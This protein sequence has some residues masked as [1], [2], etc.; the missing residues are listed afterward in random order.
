MAEQDELRSMRWELD[1]LLKRAED[2]A[3][4]LDALEA[5][6]QLA[7]PEPVEERTALSRAQSIEIPSTPAK[8]PP[9]PPQEARVETAG[10][11]VL[12]M[13]AGQSAVRPSAKPRSRWVPVHTRVPLRECS[14][15]LLRVLGPQE[16][17]DW[18]M[19]LWTHW[20]PRIGMLVLAIGVMLLLT[21]AF[22]T[23]GLRW[24]PHLRLAFGYFV[25]AVLLILGK[26][27]EQ[28]ARSYAR[29]LIAGGLG[30][31]Y[32]ATF[33][34]HYLPYTRVV[35]RPEVTLLLLAA[36]V[37]VWA[38]VAQIRRSSLV[39]FGVTALGHLTIALSTLTL[40]EPSRFG[41]VGLVALSA[42]SA[43]FL[44][45]NGWYY[46]GAAG[47]VGSYAN[48]ALW[49][50]Y[51]APSGRPIDFVAAM[52]VLVVFVLLF[53]LAEL[54]APPRL[55]R[56][57][58]S[59][60]IRSLYVAFN[61][62][63][64]FFLAL[65]IMQAFPFSRDKTYLFYFAFA[66]GLAGMS[67]AYLKARNGDPLHNVYLTKGSAVSAL[68]LAA[69]FDGPMLTISLTVQA[70]V[71]LASARRS[72][73]VSPRILSAA[74]A[75]LA[76]GHGLY[77]MA[78][79][80][81]LSY[82]AP[83]Y[84]GTVVPAL[85]SVAAFL[86]L[87]LLYQRTDWSCRSFAGEG[88]AYWLRI[89]LWNLDLLAEPPE[90][91]H[92]KPAEGLLFPYA[93]ATAAG[94]LGLAFATDFLLPP[95]RGPLL[96]LF[97]LMVAG[98]GIL[99]RSKPYTATSLLL[100]GGACF[101][102]HSHLFRLGTLAYTDPV[103]AKQ[104]L[105][106]V[107]VLIPFLVL[108]EL[109]RL[110]AGGVSRL[111]MALPLRRHQDAARPSNLPYVYAAAAA[112]LYTVS[113]LVLGQPTHRILA[114]SIGAVLAV[115]YAHT[116]AARAFG[117]GAVF[118]TAAAA[119][120]GAADFAQGGFA[121]TAALSLV[122]LGACALVSDRCAGTH[123]GAY[124]LK[125]AASPYLLYGTGA[126]LLGWF[127]TGQLDPLYRVGAL[128]ASAA[129][130]AGLM[131]RL[132]PR[133][134]GICTAGLTV[135][136]GVVLGFDPGIG[137]DGALWR[138][139]SIALPVLAL[140]GDRYL[141]R[142]HAFVRK[143]PSAILVCVAWASLLRYAGKETGNEWVFFWSVVI[144]SVFLAYGLVFRAKTAVLLA[145]FTG[146]VTLM[147]VLLRSSGGPPVPVAPLIA[148]Y[149]ALILFWALLERIYAYSA[150]RFDLPVP[151]AAPAIIEALLVAVPSALLVL[152]LKQIPGL[153]DFYLTISWSLAA[154]ALFVTA[155]M[156]G[157][158]YY[159][160]SG[161]GVFLLSLGRVV[162]VDTR[163]LDGPYRI[164]AWL[165]LGTVILAV[166]YAYVWVLRG[167]HAAR[168][169][170]GEAAGKPSPEELSGEQPPAKTGA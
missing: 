50:H 80:A 120:E 134:L 1:Q 108:A 104:I 142:R 22:R 23:W 39:A 135:W 159:R 144:G 33:A 166:A 138:I 15:R 71:L 32:L 40:G 70:I 11:P 140:T 111:W 156:T 97:A 85:L 110:A 72:A 34:T 45:R 52:G 3:R 137:T 158:K 157:Q 74:A 14:R 73:L 107:L 57:A 124:F 63:C 5:R 123:Q 163:Q 21:L 152:L 38:A 35:S 9:L 130:C 93:W 60:R 161:L 94:L 81:P 154:V 43:F 101:W 105:F 27:L 131:N 92:P 12:E 122:L 121:V 46:V 54:F 147:L 117:L 4:R 119:L 2:L 6:Q 133:A 64:F 113:A 170:Q 20:M 28:K 61:S 151:R 103:F 68:G 79:G 26:R 17:M 7:Q 95:H 118:L 16:Q 153:A 47:M 102:W 37:L 98:A 86:A 66:A 53:G 114:I 169:P 13:R 82:A 36:L 129:V 31:S 67:L 112:Q 126:W 146:T 99:V 139:A 96:S 127:L 160:Y 55:R 42:G 41:I 149:A 132:H 100:S 77:G 75:I 84:I 167:N 109:S 145:L 168:S 8:P 141:V 19:A 128:A 148:N 18:E 76:F 59:T 136:A 115:S 29:V 44:A 24:L 62:A 116:T 49:L 90:E 78:A 25:C 106:G 30:L 143:I 10:S 89:A 48:Y 125:H 165:V 164:A 162:L 87:S 58:V 91:R 65:S 56:R 88:L 69:Y 51:S 155:V 83:G 150:S